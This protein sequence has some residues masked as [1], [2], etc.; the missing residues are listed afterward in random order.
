MNLSDRTTEETLQ[1]SK[2]VTKIS[3]KVLYKMVSFMLEKRA[4]NNMK[5]IE[6]RDPSRIKTADI[7]KDNIEKFKF[8]ANENKVKAF[9]IYDTYKVP[10]LKYDIKDEHKVV[11]IFKEIEEG[12][13]IP[14]NKIKSFIINNVNIG[15]VIEILNNKFKGLDKEE[16]SKEFD[17]TEN[18]KESEVIERESGEVKKSSLKDVLKEV[19]KEH[20]EYMEKNKEKSKSQSRQKEAEHER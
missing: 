13:T 10:T 9:E 8:L 17:N 12:Y 1:T 7:E 3:L 14:E 20:K 15:K 6:K 2:E 11:N 16:I 18:Y 4:N 5:S 19:E